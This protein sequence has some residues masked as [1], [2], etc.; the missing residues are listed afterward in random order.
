MHSQLIRGFSIVIIHIYTCGLNYKDISFYRTVTRVYFYSLSFALELIEKASAVATKT[1]GTS[2]ICRAE[3]LSGTS[4]SAAKTT[5]RL[6][7]IAALSIFDYLL[8]KY[9]DSCQW[10]TRASSSLVL[11]LDIRYTTRRRKKKKKRRYL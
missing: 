1:P 3:N 11:S 4:P 2:R 5:I 9:I 10:R 6:N 8:H 7:F